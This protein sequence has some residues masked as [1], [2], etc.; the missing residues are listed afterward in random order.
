ME[1][2]EKKAP[3]IVFTDPSIPLPTKYEAI[4]GMEN[5]AAMV[6]ARSADTMYVV[7]ERAR[8]YFRIPCIILPVF[9]TP[10]MHFC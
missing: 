5:F 7:Q 2:S 6:E 10:M 1:N 8:M 3:D 9:K 4:K